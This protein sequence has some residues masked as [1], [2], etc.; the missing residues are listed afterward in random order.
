MR[1]LVVFVAASMPVVNVALADWPQFRG[2][3]SASVATGPPPPVEFGPGKNELWRVPMGSG[4][5]S[6][7]IVGDSIFLTTYEEKQK[8]LAVV[9]IERT[10][11]QTRWQR[12]VPTDRIE[13]GHPSF[14]PA[15]STPACDG[16]RVVA[17]SGSFGLICF[18]KGVPIRAP[19][20]VE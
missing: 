14:N 4:H 3:N 2:L 8:K 13:K 19:E 10:S 16:E 17:Y 18:D 9:C 11:G 15:S 6:P 20:N 7:C 12:D 1:I 5:S